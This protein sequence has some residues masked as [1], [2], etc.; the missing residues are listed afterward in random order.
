VLGSIVVKRSNRL[1][2]LLGLIVAISGAV[3]AAVVANGS[4][5]GGNA[6]QAGSSASPTP[7]PEPT[8][9]VVVAKQDIHA[10][11]QITAEMVGLKPITLS[12]RDALGADTFSSVDQVIGNIAGSDIG[13]GKAIVASRDFISTSGAV[14]E[15]KDLSGAITKG[16]V[17]VSMEIDQ[18]NGVGTLIV[19]GDH[20]DIILS[21][22]VDALALTAP[23]AAKN[24]IVLAGGQQVTSK[25][26]IRNRRILATLLPPAEPVGG[27]PTA[28]PSPLGATPAPSAGVIQFNSRHM[29]AIVEVM[30]EE[31]E[32]IRWAQR[33]EKLDP[34]NY[35]DLSFALRSRADDD[36]KGSHT[37]TAGITYY[38]LV[39]NYGVL[40]PDPRAMIPSKLGIVIQW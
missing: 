40:P 6:N 36:T 39:Q 27:A 31:A 11:D 18:T 23:D 22:Y 2:I 35:I 3:A 32:V 5:G 16:M 19:P 30:P 26:V 28:N 10:G 37:D 38:Q 7:T 29:V 24:S 25:M 34:Q 8:V 4:G 15:G 9:Q 14:S 1:L 12:E 33:A 20:V 17:A 21:V 13:N